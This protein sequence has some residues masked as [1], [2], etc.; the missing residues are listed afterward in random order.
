MTDTEWVQNVRAEN[1]V[2]DIIWPLAN[3]LWRTYSEVS[4]SD[5]SGALELTVQRK[6]HSQAVE[7][8]KHIVRLVPTEETRMLSRSPVLKQTDICESFYWRGKVQV[9]LL[10]MREA[11]QWLDKAW[12][13]CPETSH[14]QRR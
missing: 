4:C 8:E 7:I 14:D 11:K 12:Q 13:T 2:G 10:N 1:S 9:V 3:I 5:P 6:L